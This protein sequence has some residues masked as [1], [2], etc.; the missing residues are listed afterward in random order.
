LRDLDGALVS[1][2]QQIDARGGELGHTLAAADRS[3]REAQKLLESLNAAT[4]PGSDFRGD[5]QATMRDFA[6]SASSLRDFAETIERNPNAIVMGR[7]SR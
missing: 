3:M 4:E 6:A 1:V 7:S 2:H 5:L